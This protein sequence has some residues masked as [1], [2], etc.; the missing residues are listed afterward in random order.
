MQYSLPY[1]N[2]KQ[3]VSIPNSCSVEFISS[4]STQIP[5]NSEML[6]ENAFSNPLNSATISDSPHLGD[7]IVIVVDDHTR[8]CPTKQILPYL[9][10]LLKKSDIPAS[11]ITI[12]IATGTHHPPDNNQ[13]KQMFG[14]QILQEYKIVSNDTETS[15]YVSVGRSTYGHEISINKIYVDADVKIIL[16]DIEYHYFAGFGG[17]RKSILPGIASKETIQHN[18]AMMFD[19]HATT[20]E[21]EKNPVSIEMQEAFDMVGCDFCIGAV[22]NQDH[23][24]VGVWTGDALKVMNHGVTLVKKLYSKKINCEPDLVIIAADG[25]PHDLNLYQSL[26]ALHTASNV[27]KKNGTIIF[28]AECN[29]GLGSNIYKHWLERYETA[30][31]IQKQLKKHFEIGAHKA[32]YHRDIIERLTVYLSSNF[33]PSYVKKIGFI[34]AKSIQEAFNNAI[35]KKDSIE[36]ILIVPNG[37]TTFLYR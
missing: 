4:L 35:S 23:H 2:S 8:P 10:N 24:I 36:K 22:L 28:A 32:Y 6:I 15:S 12:L 27:I 37:S 25:F 9:L 31:E 7:S 19:E 34:P 29:E 11:D 30:N 5:P 13:L 20:G 14:K 16:S 3:V 26:K 1:G 17:T 21:L 33:H 18:H